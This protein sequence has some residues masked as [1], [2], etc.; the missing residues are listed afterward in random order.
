MLSLVLMRLTW[1]GVIMED[2]RGGQG[3]WNCLA[4]LGI[5][6][7]VGVRSPGHEEASA[8]RGPQRGW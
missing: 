4:C 6:E 5:G 2:K 3:V 7:G 1:Y 8:E